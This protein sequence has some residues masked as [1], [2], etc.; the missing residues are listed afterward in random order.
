MAATG[1]AL[2]PEQLPHLPRPV[3][4]PRLLVQRPHAIQQ[5]VVGLRPR[6]LCPAPPG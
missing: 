4:F 5:R 1:Q 2:A 3:S 6:A